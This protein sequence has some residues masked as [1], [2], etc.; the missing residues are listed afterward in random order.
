MLQ[1]NHF[2]FLRLCNK[3]TKL[4]NNFNYLFFISQ[5]EGATK[6]RSGQ[7]RKE[8]HIQEQKDKA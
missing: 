8:R 3:F 5:E 4:I 7:R 6:E 2:K 1:V